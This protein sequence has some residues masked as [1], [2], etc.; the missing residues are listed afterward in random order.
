MDKNVQTIAICLPI[1]ILHSM[2]GWIRINSFIRK[3]QQ[4]Q[5]LN[6]T[7][8]KSKNDSKLA[9]I[10]VV[11]A[12]TLSIVCKMM[13]LVMNLVR[14]QS[15]LPSSVL[16]DEGKERVETT[17][18]SEDNSITEELEP[19]QQHPLILFW[20][21]L[22]I[23]MEA[24]VLT[25]NTKNKLF[26]SKKHKLTQAVAAYKV[27]IGVQKTH[28][29]VLEQMPELMQCSIIG[30]LGLMSTTS[31]TRINFTQS[32]QHQYEITSTKRSLFQI[33]QEQS[34]IR[35][36]CFLSQVCSRTND[37]AADASAHSFG[38]SATMASYIVTT[39]HTLRK[40]MAIKGYVT[41]LIH[42]CD[43]P[44]ILPPPRAINMQIYK[45]CF[46]QP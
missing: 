44:P 7:T 31:T 22:Q 26:K 13:N 32:Q 35:M 29:S 8:N 16:L 12:T 23:M 1:V 30:L 3:Q 4:E 27:S 20:N 11:A 10:K 40:S 37:G 34:L 36:V 41:F 24:L 28:Y 42:S 17:T 18:E 39:M 5:Q 46:K 43:V 15:S 2:Q 45:N 6:V 19:K 33:Q 14:K 38:I 25:P 21:N 9:E